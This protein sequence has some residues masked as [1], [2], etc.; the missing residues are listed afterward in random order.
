M[1]RAALEVAVSRNPLDMFLTNFG[2]GI[3][4]AAVEGKPSTPIKEQ[5]LAAAE[6]TSKQVTAMAKVR[7]ELD[8]SKTTKPAPRARR[9]PRAT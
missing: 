4:Q 7:A 1:A 9:A 6:K 5:L 3:M 8:A 2:F